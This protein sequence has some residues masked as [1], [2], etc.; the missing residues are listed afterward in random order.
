MT[1]V[2]RLLVETGL[3]KD[4]SE[5]RR[6]LAQGAVTVDGRPVGAPWARVPHGALVRVGRTRCAVAVWGQR[7]G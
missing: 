7:G 2:L 3:A 6:V 1:D 5:A 4:R